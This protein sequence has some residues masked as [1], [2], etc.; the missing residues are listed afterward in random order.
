MFSVGNG[1][2]FGNQQSEGPLGDIEQQISGVLN[3]SD[4]HH[5][6]LPAGPGGIISLPRPQD[7]RYN[8]PPARDDRGVAGPSLF[9]GPARPRERLTVSDIAVL[10]AGLVILLAVVAVIAAVAVTVIK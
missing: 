1:N 3:S 9:T 7:P 8:R 6:Y 2:L 10:V 4:D 5:I